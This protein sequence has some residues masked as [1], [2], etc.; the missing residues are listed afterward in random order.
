M[1]WW[2]AQPWWSLGSQIVAAVTTVVLLLLVVLAIFLLVRELRKSPRGPEGVLAERFAQ[3][4]IDEHEFRRRLRIMR[5]ELSED[6]KRSKDATSR[7]EA[8]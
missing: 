3:G 1:W 2:N 4:E 8:T 7:F 5:E 6:T